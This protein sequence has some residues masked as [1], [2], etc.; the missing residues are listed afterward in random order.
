MMQV[1]L[2]AI[3]GMPDI[4]PGDDLAAICGDAL[5]AAGL[6]PMESDILCLAQ[7]IFS[8]A[9]GCLV[10]YDGITPS[11]QALDLAE[12]LGKDPRRLQ[13]VLNES[14]RIVRSFRAP[15]A[16]EGTLICEH[17]L[18]F[19]SANAAVDESNIGRQDAALV[20][21]NDPDASCQALAEAISAR[22]GVSVGVVMTDT[23][24]RPWRLGQVNVAI[25]LADVPATIREQG[26]VDAWGRTLQVTEPALADEIAAATGLVV[27]KSAR[28][29][30]VL[31][32]GMD[33]TART[34]SSARD[35]LRRPEEDAFR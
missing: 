23:F 15:G 12:E 7:K 26:N 33:W 21:P 11:Q 20:L 35:L 13:V 27:R 17:R 30:L 5:V 18:G 19:I 22:F 31:L 3:P 29:P 14:R 25:G 2:T 34:G 4:E 32:R 9:E 24:G 1:S 8:K 16:K 6:A 10:P 28:T